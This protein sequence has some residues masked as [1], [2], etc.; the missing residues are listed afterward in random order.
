MNFTLQDALT[1]QQLQLEEWQA[2]LQPEIYNKLENLVLES[3]KGETNPLNIVR[4][5]QIYVELMNS[6][7]K[8]ASRLFRESNP[9]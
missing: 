9:K 3:N 4:G 1:I 7:R 6:N 5:N 8:K 2:L